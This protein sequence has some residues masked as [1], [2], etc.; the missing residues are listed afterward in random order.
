MNKQI[1]AIALTASERHHAEQQRLESE[2]NRIN[3]EAEQAARAAAKKPLD[4]VAADLSANTHRLNRLTDLTTKLE[5]LSE[6]IKVAKIDVA[7][8][9]EL[10]AELE[11]RW[12]YSF[13]RRH[14]DSER[15]NPLAGAYGDAV[16]D[17][18]DLLCAPV[19][20][21]RLQAWIAAR[22]SELETVEAEIAEIDSKSK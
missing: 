10:A 5:T 14:M 22:Q 20:L 18:L 19:V 9:T 15:L 17:R 2:R 21:P 4:K 12:Q 7:Q 6:Q 1:H 8:Q 13:G 16:R 11:R 3:A